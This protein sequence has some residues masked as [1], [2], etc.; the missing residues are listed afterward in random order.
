MHSYAGTVGSEA[1]KGLG[2]KN[3]G[4]K[5]AVVR[6]VYLSAIVMDVGH[7]I[8]EATGDG[9]IDKERTLMKVFSYLHFSKRR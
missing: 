3:R 6:L 1:V 9:P 4:E 5:S 8:W 7:W 2:K